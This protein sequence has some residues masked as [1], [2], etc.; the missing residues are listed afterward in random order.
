MICISHPPS[1]DSGA[2]SGRRRIVRRPLENSHAGI[3]RTVNQIT[4]TVIAKILSPGERT[5][6][7]AGVKQIIRRSRGDET[8]F[9]TGFWIS[10]RASSRRRLRHGAGEPSAVPLKIRAIKKAAS[11]SEGRLAFN[12][13]SPHPALPPSPQ[14]GEGFICPVS[15]AESAAWA[16][17]RCGRRR[18]PR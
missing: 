4:E 18:C 14:S 11:V 13:V 8:H 6:V 2:T 9:K 12:F 7:R 1:S 10:V 16:V 15:R 3:G 17:C 5:Q